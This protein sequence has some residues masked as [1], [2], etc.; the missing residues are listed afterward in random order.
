[1]N[2]IAGSSQFK[3]EVKKS[4]VK[5]TFRE[6]STVTGRGR[7]RSISRAGRIRG[8][9]IGV[10]V[11]SMTNFCYMIAPI[12]KFERQDEMFATL[13][14]GRNI[15]IR[16]QDVERIG[17]VAMIYLHG[18]NLGVTEM[19]ISNI[20]LVVNQTISLFSCKRD[21]EILPQGNVIFVGPF[22]C[23]HDI[24]IPG[25]ERQLL[26]ANGAPTVTL[27][28]SGEVLIN[29]TGMLVGIVKEIDQIDAT[30]AINA[31]DIRR[32][33]MRN[34]ESIAAFR[35]RIIANAHP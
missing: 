20:P 29:D 12:T 31:A 9:T 10:V 18:T 24:S 25:S 27:E 33:I 2:N 8:R 21:E 28:D 7:S 13:P 1:M 6:P 32:Y 4:M 19:V 16:D 15:D 5:I 3:E 23:K 22:H 34:N 30:E 14:N 26:D 17:S 11:V 35:Q